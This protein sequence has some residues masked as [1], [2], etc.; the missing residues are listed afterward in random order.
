MPRLYEGRVG[1]E[2]ECLLQV[3]EVAQGNDLSLKYYIRSYLYCDVHT[4]I[5][6]VF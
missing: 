3:G 1:G 6:I 5:N 4:Y 2:G